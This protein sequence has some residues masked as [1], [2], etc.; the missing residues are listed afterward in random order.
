M[1]GVIGASTE[2]SGTI[3]IPERIHDRI[4][5]DFGGNTS[6]YTGNTTINVGTSSG[7]RNKT[8]SSSNDTE[9][10]ETR[11]AITPIYA[12]SSIWICWQMNPH[13]N[14]LDSASRN[15][16][17]LLGRNQSNSSIPIHSFRITGRNGEYAD[18]TKNIMMVDHPNSTD[19]IT[20]SIFMSNGDT[21]VVYYT[22]QYSGV[23]P[24]SAIA[25]EMPHASRTTSFKWRAT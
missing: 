2:V 9:F 10:T 5:F 12:D 16:Q 20:Y 7:Y 23:H 15:A 13:I 19:E 14:A 6:R 11:I 4:D 1:S 17:M 21:A 22:H 24:I 8:L 18:K 3:G 25:R